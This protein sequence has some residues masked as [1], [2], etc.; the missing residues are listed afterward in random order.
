MTRPARPPVKPTKSEWRKIRR[1]VAEHEAG[2]GLAVDRLVRDSSERGWHLRTL[3]YRAPAA[4]DVV[5]SATIPELPGGPPRIS[6]D[7][8]IG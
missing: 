5:Y 2:T 7:R 4:S 3:F 6:P 8:R 1:L